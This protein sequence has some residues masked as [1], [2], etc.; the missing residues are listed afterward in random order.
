MIYY[1][2]LGRTNY[3]EERP[4]HLIEDNRTLKPVALLASS[5]WP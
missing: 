1:D 2:I 4:S 5:H 3:G